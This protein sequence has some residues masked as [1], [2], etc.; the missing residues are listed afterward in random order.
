M[1]TYGGKIV[2]QTEFIRNLNCN[3]ERIRLEQ[4]P[5][6]NRYQYC[7]ITR[8]GIKGLL[9]CSLR[10]IDEGAYLY[11]DITSTQNVA[12]LYIG[13]MIDKKWM[14][15]F[16]WGLNQVKQELAR[17]LLDDRNILWFPEQIFQDLEKNDFYFLYI[18]YYAENCGFL[19]LIEFLVDHIDYEEEALVEFVYKMHEQYELL[20]S[21]YLQEQIFE[22][23]VM[24]EEPRKMVLSIEEAA[25][26]IALEKDNITDMASQ[27]NTTKTNYA[28]TTNT[29]KSISLKTLKHID[30]QEELIEERDDKET[31]KEK[32]LNEVLEHKSKKSENAE[33]NAPSKR[34]LR[35]LL[36]GGRKRR[37]KE[38]RKAYQEEFK[39]QLNKLSVAEELLYEPED[40][41][42]TIYLEDST[43]TL[44]TFRCLYTKDNRLAGE[45]NN[46]PYLIGK[47]KDEVNCCLSDRSV[48]RVHARIIKE[49]GEYYLEDLNATNGTYKN[50]LRLQ[51]YEKRLLEPE[52]E[53]KFGKVI[54]Y[55]R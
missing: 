27:I 14:K 43:E 3:Y 46:T 19:E 25:K 4:K 20:G 9:T 41:G 21:I 36:E 34:S 33:K 45:L 49:N 53:I 6:E 18:P 10:Y 12:Q 28:K 42:K 37:Q 40:Y 52:D 5:E 22:D 23:A 35:Y 24:L 30:S 54:L 50:G 47:K 55:F 29:Q 7:I 26:V 38:E 31:I 1:N 16:L 48:S 2:L 11:Y 15:D 13:R 44:E 32:D 8:G 17:F 51:P 39:Q